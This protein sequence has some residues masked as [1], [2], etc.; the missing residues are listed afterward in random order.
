MISGDLEQQKGLQLTTEI[1][2]RTMLFEMEQKY[3][4][5]PKVLITVAML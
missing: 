5:D 3:A 4:S 2:E 1:K